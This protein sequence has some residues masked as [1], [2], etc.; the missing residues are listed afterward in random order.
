MSAEHDIREYYPARC[1]FCGHIPAKAEWAW[2]ARVRC[3]N[4]GAWGPETKMLVPNERLDNMMFRA[5][6]NWNNRSG[7]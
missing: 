3:D 6:Q 1:P 4:C 2:S 7:F 5:V